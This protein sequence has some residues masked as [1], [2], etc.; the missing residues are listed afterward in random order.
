MEKFKVNN[1]FP[2]IIL[3]V[4]VCVGFVLTSGCATQSENKGKGP[5]ETLTAC[6]TAKIT[7]LEY[8]MKKCVVHQLTFL[9]IP[10]RIRSHLRP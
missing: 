9:R 8:F 4:V 7:T 2:G 10:V 3:L 1:L 6:P 5:A